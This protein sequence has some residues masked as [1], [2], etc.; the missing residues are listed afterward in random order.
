MATNTLSDLAL[1]LRE[2]AAAY[3]EAQKIPRYLA[4]VYHAGEQT[5][6]A[7]G[8]ANIVTE[9]PMRE[10]TGFLFGSVTK[11]LTTTLALQ[12]VE[13]GVLDLEERVITHLPEFRLTTPG[14][15]EQIRVRHL[16]THTNGI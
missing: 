2:Q 3:C 7:H 10:N 11:L 9:A 15:A 16:L 13:R 4:G 12:Q 8:V 6:V 5:I 14:A 1:R